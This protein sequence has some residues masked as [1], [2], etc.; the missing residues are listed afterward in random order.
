MFACTCNH[1]EDVISAVS[2]VGVD[3]AG[4]EPILSHCETRL[5]HPDGLDLGQPVQV[6]L[7]ADRLLVVARVEDVLSGTLANL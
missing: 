1:F 4:F 7:V 6:D 3:V 5:R 2:G